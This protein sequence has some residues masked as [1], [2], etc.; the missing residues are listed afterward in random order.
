MDARVK[1]NHWCFTYEKQ[2]AGKCEENQAV[3]GTCCLRCRAMRSRHRAGRKPELKGLGRMVVAICTSLID[4]EHF[5]FA[6]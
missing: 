6:N 1:A 4:A 5:N 3:M 2:G